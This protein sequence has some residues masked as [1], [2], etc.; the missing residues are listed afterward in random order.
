MLIK[1]LEVQNELGLHARAASRIVR[2]ARKFHSSVIIRKEGGAY[3]LRS[4]T[5]VITVN[6]KHGDILTAEFDGDDE[7]AAAEAFEALFQNKFGEK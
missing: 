3:D 1:Q 6:G 2:E 7:E 5:A 4:V